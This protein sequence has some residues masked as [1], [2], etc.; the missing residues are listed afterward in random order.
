MRMIRLRDC[1]LFWGVIP[2][3]PRRDARTSVGCD[4]CARTV[5]SLMGPSEVKVKSG[6]RNQVGIVI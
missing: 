3:S 4:G 2:E 1:T 5:P 6:G